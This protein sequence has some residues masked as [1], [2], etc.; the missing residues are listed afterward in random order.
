MNSQTKSKAKKQPKF[1]TNIRT[2]L[3]EIGRLLAEHRSSKHNLQN[4]TKPSK[5]ETHKTIRT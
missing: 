2:Q 4:I 5:L 3:V 1:I